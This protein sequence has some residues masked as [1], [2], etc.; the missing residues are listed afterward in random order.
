MFYKGGYK[1]LY[2]LQGYYVPTNRI[3][4]TGSDWTRQFNKNV[5]LFM[6][7]LHHFMFISQ[8][9]ISEDLEHLHMPPFF[10]HQ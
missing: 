8:N 6:H 3:I 2:K 5:C 7:L 1:I 9:T 4:I 10:A